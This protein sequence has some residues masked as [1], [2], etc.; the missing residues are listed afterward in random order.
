MTVSGWL[1]HILLSILIC[2]FWASKASSYANPLPFIDLDLDRGNTWIDCVCVTLYQDS[3]LNVNLWNEPE[4]LVHIFNSLLSV[5]Q[6]VRNSPRSAS[7]PLQP[8]EFCRFSITNS[9][10]TPRALCTQ[11]QQQ[12]QRSS[13]YDHSRRAYISISSMKWHIPGRR[14]RRLTR[15][16][17]TTCQSPMLL[18]SH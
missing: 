8:L 6:L 17:R 9:N 7:S 4:V 18:N 1:P 15:L 5:S 16:L 2:A 14:T 13:Q 11:H 12:H 3:P 10:N